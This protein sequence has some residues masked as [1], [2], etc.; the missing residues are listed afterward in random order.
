MRI[1][2]D[3]GGTFTDLVIESD[4]GVLGL[5]KAASTPDDPVQGVLD[6]ISLAAGARG[7][8][9]NQLLR[10]TE[11]LL[12]GTTRAL[13]AILSG[14]T[15]RTALLVTEGHEDLLVLREGERTGAFDFRREYPQPYVPR[16][17]TFGIHEWIGSGGEIV[18]ALDEAQV[19]SLADEL[20]RVGV[21]AVAVCL[22]WSIANP[23]H[24]LQV[25]QLL[26]ESLPGIP[27]T[28]SHALNPVIR[29]YR[30]ASSTAIDASLRPLMTDYV[31]SFERRLR[32]AGF[33]GR[34]LMVTSSGGL[35]DFESMSNS[36][37]HALRSGPSMAPVAGR[38]TAQR[39]ASVDNTIVLDCGGTSFDVSLV[40]LGRISR[41]NETWI[42]PRFF[43][44]MTGFSSV[45]V[46]S[47]GAGGRSIACR[48]RWFA[49]CW[50]RERWR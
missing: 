35:L 7:E 14:G 48:R 41:T 3:V 32:E 31:A 15:A 6:V 22:L 49:P 43:G 28:L 11:L 16:S 29:E 19:R 5:F 21:E 47:I 2:I 38:L 23:V 24:E 42:G 33:A 26:R 20:L 46:R 27:I 39:D 9:P 50:P 8:P 4:N 13:N 17:L 25:D 1:A 45:D 12:H 18:V 40:R 30:R 34:A 36:P 10:R 44:T 37:V